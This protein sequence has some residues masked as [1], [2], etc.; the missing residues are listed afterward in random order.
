M[1]HDR[2]VKLKR[3]VL[4]FAVAVFAAGCTTIVG[5]DRELH[6]VGVYEGF[7]RQQGDNGSPQARVVVDRPGKDI[8][9]LLGSF[10]G[11][12]WN[13]ELTPNTRLEKLVLYGNGRSSSRVV[14]N[15]KTFE[16]FERNETIPYV[17]ADEGFN[18]RLLV[19]NAPNLYGFSQLDSFHGGYTAVRVGFHV[20]ERQHYLPH[21]RPNYL[22]DSV[23]GRN[24][25]PDITFEATL[26][27]QTGH[28]NLRGVLLEKASQTYD[29][30]YDVKTVFVTELG[31]T[32]TFNEKG[33]A[34]R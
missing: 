4:S 12:Q 28:Y 19:E 22:S 9:L 2:F 26:N 1:K 20:V 24:N 27:G 33:F 29:Q 6:A 30:P 21:L 17:Y 14:L 15:E 34:K 18:F 7:E 5:H 23:V 10:N 16:R 31:A 8:V 32:F 13:V 3:L 25:L 11:V